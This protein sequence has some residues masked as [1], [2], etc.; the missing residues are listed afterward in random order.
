MFAKAFLLVR[1]LSAF[2]VCSVLCL[3]T[4]QTQAEIRQGEFPS[5]QGEDRYYF[6]NST[7]SNLNFDEVDLAKAIVFAKETQSDSLV[8]IRRGKIVV[9]QYWNGKTREDVQQMYSSTKSPFSFL[10]GRLIAKSKIKGL[11]QPL[12]EIVPEMKGES[13]ERITFRGLMAMASGL[14]QSRTIDIKDRQ[15]ES[16]QL[17]SVLKRSVTSDPLTK[18][19]YNNA[20]YRA[21]FT[22]LERATGNTLHEITTKELFEPLG[23]KGAYWVELHS[24]ERFLGYQSIRM[25]PLDMAKIGQIMIDSGSWNGDTF[26]DPKFIAELVRPIPGDVNP[27]YGLLW[28]LNGE[29]YRGYYV[30]SLIN[31]KPLEGTPSDAF[32]NYGSGGQV[33]VCV[34]SLELVWVRTGSEMPYSMYQPMSTLSRLSSLICQSIQR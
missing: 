28:H 18:Y 32:F 29:Y 20:G 3:A 33:L 22:A 15:Q 24:G 25:R 2:A 27:S 4:W 12:V 11:D 6:E 13:L 26:L 17:Q 16:T 10:I 23:M 30:P 14:E 7:L 9:E 19:H 8:I 31:R 21:M 34:P 1:C 5:W